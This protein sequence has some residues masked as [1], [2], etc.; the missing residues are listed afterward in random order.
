MAALLATLAH[1]EALLKKQQEHLHGSD[2]ENYGRPSKNAETSSESSVPITP[3]SGSGS[4]SLTGTNGRQMRNEVT[5]SEADEVERLRRQLAEANTRLAQMDQELSQTRITKH[6][7]D[8]A[9]GSPSESDFR[10]PAIVTEQTI[11]SLQGALNA[12]T[13]A[14]LGRTNSWGAVNDGH[15]KPSDAASDG[16]FGKPLPI[17]GNPR[18]TPLQ[19]DLARTSHVHDDVHGNIHGSVG[20]PPSN[21]NHGPIRPPAPQAMGQGMFSMAP[22]LSLRGMMGSQFQGMVGHGGG[23][24]DSV[25]LSTFQSSRRSQAHMGRGGP[26]HNHRAPGWGAYPTN[27]G[28]GEGAG[29]RT[30]PYQSHNLIQPANE[31]RQ[32]PIGTPLSATAPEFKLMTGQRNA[33]LGQVG[34]D[35]APITVLVC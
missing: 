4:G 35:A 21:W 27:V 32:L 28:L 17:W 9:L 15:S 18:R 24:H 1:Q 23:L 6:T 2:N 12:S 25:P 31:Y 10:V 30:A 22:Q 7:L 5:S 8:Q 13:R 33:W 3:A 34:D 19:S 26:S 14:S 16:P 11:S 29:S 20:D